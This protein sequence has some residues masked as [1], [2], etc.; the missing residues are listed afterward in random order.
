MKKGRTRAMLDTNAINRIADG[1]LELAALSQYELLLTHVQ[2][3]EIRATRESQRITDLLD[4]CE[5]IA[6]RSVP[7]SSSAWDVSNW[8]ESSWDANGSYCRILAR[9]GELDDANRKKRSAQS[10]RVRDALIGATSI[11]EECVLLS[12]DRN[13]IQAVRECSG[14]AINVDE[15]DLPH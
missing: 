9:I 11:S 3:D 2:I 5:M 12:A 6:A 14:H 8:D 10:N 1:R 7:T 4:V 13:L 15:G